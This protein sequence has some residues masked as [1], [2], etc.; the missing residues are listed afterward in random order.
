MERSDDAGAVTS[1]RKLIGAGLATTGAAYVAPQILSTAVAGAQ[2]QT[3]YAFKIEGNN[4]SC[5]GESDLNDSGCGANFNAAFA[6]AGSRL[7][8]QGCP[9]AGT[10]DVTEGGI[11]SEAGATIE[12]GP[13]CT[14]VFAGFKAGNACYWPGGS[15]GNGIDTGASVVIGGDTKSVRIESS[16]GISH[17]VFI[18]CCSG[19][20][21][22]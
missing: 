5:V 8:V 18:V 6:G 17:M 7:N 1:R 3:C 19:S 21:V 20:P 22:G 9:P 10:I 4:T 12:A 16:R 15:E 14:F 13:N 2:S 11:N